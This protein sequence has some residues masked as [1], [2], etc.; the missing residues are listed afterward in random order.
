MLLEETNSIDISQGIC[1][2]ELRLS[3]IDAGIIKDPI[4]R[5]KLFFLKLNKYKEYIFYKDGLKE[6]FIEGSY[7]NILIDYF[8]EIE[9]TCDMKKFD[10]IYITK[11]LIVKVNFTHLSIEKLNSFQK[12]ALFGIRNKKWWQI[13]IP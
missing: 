9:P 10:D 8:Y 6:D 5:E 11:E 7:K 12:K 2:S 3:I 4:K 13:W 1:N